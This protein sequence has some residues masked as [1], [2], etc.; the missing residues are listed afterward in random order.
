MEQYGVWHKRCEA[1][2]VPV[3]GEMSLPKLGL[4]DETWASL[5]QEVRYQ[6]GRLCIPRAKPVLNDGG[7]FAQVDVILHLASHVHFLY[8][9]ELLKDANVT[10][11][12]V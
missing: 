2:V 9:Y 11:T 4:G 10:G 8:P 1:C 5:S 7:S 6:G 3:I 12:L